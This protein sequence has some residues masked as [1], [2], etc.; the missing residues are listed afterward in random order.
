MATEILTVS[1]QFSH[2]ARR[3]A[4]CTFLRSFAGS[5]DT[6]F[7]FSHSPSTDGKTVWL[8]E[9]APSDES[10]ETLTLGH[11]IH[12]MMH[13][14]HT[15]FSAA[16]ALYPSI[17]SQPLESWYSQSESGLNSPGSTTFFLG[18]AV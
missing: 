5:G 4:V 1:D 7:L 13:V 6:H 8:G 12:E 2:S 17:I 3:K 15:D 10:F 16:L 18:L 9:C 11:G 14:A